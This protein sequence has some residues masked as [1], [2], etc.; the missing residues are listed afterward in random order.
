VSELI[1]FYHSDLVD[2]LYY[3]EYHGPSYKKIKWL[4]RDSNVRDLYKLIREIK[5]T[6]FK[7]FLPWARSIAALN[8]LETPKKLAKYIKNNPPKGKFAEKWLEEIDK[9]EDILSEIF[10]FYKKNILHDDIKK[11]LE[12]LREDIEKKYKKYWLELKEES[13]KLPGIVWKRKDPIIC[14]IYPIEGRLSHKLKYADIAYIETSEIM[15]EDEVL[16]L[17]EIVKLLNY[18]KP[19][20]AWVKQDRRGVRA[21][22]YELFTEMQTL[23]LVEKL[24]KKKPNFKKVILEKLDTLWIPLIRAETSFDEEELERILTKAYR[25]IPNHE[26]DALYQIGELYTELNIILLT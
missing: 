17:H 7:H 16:F 9:L 14:L 21:I 2:A 8:D 13:K 22:A 3:F 10:N 15:L 24:L 12:R 1:K 11:K 25:N 20:E 18:S 6:R 4:P 23:R 5:F 26:F 19:A